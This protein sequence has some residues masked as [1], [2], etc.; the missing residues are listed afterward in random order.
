MYMYLYILIYTYI[1]THIYMSIC[2]LFIHL[3]VT[4]LAQ[5]KYTKKKRGRKKEKDIIKFDVL[6]THNIQ[7]KGVANFCYICNLM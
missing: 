7:H 4:Y 3:N 5:R 2:N 1:C 6:I